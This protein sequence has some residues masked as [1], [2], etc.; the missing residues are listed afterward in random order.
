[1]LEGNEVWVAP[2]YQRKFR[3]DPKRCSQLIESVLLG[4]PVPSLFMA[5]NPDNTWEVVDGVQRLSSLVKFAGTDSL[6]KKLG[7]GDELVLTELQKLSHFDGLRYSDLPSNIQL[8]FRTRPLKVITLND[9]SDKIVRYDLFERLN[10]GGVA[11]SAQEIRDCVYQGEF[12]LLL[13]SL[14]AEKDFKTVVRLTNLQQQDGTAEECVLRFFAYLDEYKNFEHGV[15]SFLNE[16][17]SSATQKFDSKKKE[18]LFLRT[19]AELAKAF[20][21]GLSRPGRRGTT[22]L[23]LYEGVAV[24]A[25]LVLQKTDRLVTKDIDSWM[26]SPTL[27][28]FTTGATNSLSAVKGRIEFC[29]DYFAGKKYVRSSEK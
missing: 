2:I 27:R 21:H 20:P 15:T 23:N 14:A 4:I 7:L 3:W 22:P 12:S 5:T 11:L 28:R 1:M 9:K 25:A 24:G 16:Y 10:T 19:F 26:A 6:R 18:L 8:H 29:R 13:E 17:M